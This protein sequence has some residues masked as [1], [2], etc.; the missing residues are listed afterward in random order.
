ML[1]SR[2]WFKYTVAALLRLLEATDVQTSLVSSYCT[3]TVRSTPL[4][5]AIINRLIP[6][7]SIRVFPAGL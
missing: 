1:S 4:S 3:V 5:V 2:S 6:A 7:E